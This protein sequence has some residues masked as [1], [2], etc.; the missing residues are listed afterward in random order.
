MDK[1]QKIAVFRFGIISPVIHGNYKNQSRYFKEMARTEY[2]VP[3][4]GRVKYKWRTFK[5]WLYRYRK[6]GFDGL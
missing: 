3:G 5:R 1:K 6:Y 2:D 4:I